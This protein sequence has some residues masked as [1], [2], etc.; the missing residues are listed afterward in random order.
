MHAVGE[1]GYTLSHL[2]QKEQYAALCGFLLFLC[3]L[4]L[5]TSDREPITEERN[6]SVI[7]HGNSQPMT[8]VRSIP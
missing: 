1:D 8:Q 6:D 5:L 2:K 7:E 3:G 4:S